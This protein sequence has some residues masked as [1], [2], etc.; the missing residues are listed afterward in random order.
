VIKEVPKMAITVERATTREVGFAFLTAGPAY[1][2]DLPDYFDGLPELSSPL[3]I[4]GHTGAR[5][6]DF[7]PTNRDVGVTEEHRVLDSLTDRDGRTVEVYE[8]VDEPP[9]R[10]LRWSLANGALY[11]HVREEDGLDYGEVVA[12]SLSIVEDPAG[13]TP[14]LLPSRPL[15]R[16]ASAQP[17]YQ[18]LSA[19]LSAQRGWNVVFS[20]PGFIAGGRTVRMPRGDTGDQVVLRAGGPDG[21]EVTVMSGT[22]EAAGRALMSTVLSSLKERR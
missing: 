20:R 15:S 12:K 8:R 3:N 4:H 1:D 16:G 2:V 9:Q 13:G 11:T 5:S 19:F 10:Y 6:F 17:G 21:I 22:D 14:T 18:E 7:V